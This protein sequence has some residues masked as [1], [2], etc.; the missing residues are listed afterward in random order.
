V[1]GVA[2]IFT[3]GLLDPALAE[4]AGRLWPLGLIAFGVVLLISYLRR[5]NGTA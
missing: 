4:Q 1:G 5:P 2:I 3:R